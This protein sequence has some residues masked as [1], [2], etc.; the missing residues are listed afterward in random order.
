MLGSPDQAICE[1]LQAELDDKCQ[2]TYAGVD[3][4]WLC[5][6]QYAPL[7]DAKSTEDCA[8]RL[9]LPEGNKFARIYLT[10]AAPLNECGDYKALR[11]CGDYKALRI[12]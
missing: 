3:E 4:A 2:K 5:I 6:D 8:K 11:M 9:R 7:S 10:Y 1:R 12:L